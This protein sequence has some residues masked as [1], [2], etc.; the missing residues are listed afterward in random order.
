MTDTNQSETDFDGARH[1]LL[2]GTE[3]QF[4]LIWRAFRAHRLAMISLY[5]LGFLYLIA[6]FAEFVAPNDPHAVNAR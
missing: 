3:T 2:E 6:A 5:V 1:V 4:Q